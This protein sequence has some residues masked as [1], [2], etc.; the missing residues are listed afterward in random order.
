MSVDIVMRTKDRPFFLSRA[1]DD[2]LAQA[3]TDWRLII[4]NDGGDPELV[5]QTVGHRPELTGRTE[6]IHL[7]ESLGRG[8]AIDRGV[9]AC[10]SEMI[11]WHDDD[12]TWH[13]EFLARTTAFLDSSDADAVAVRTEIVWEQVSSDRVVETGREI[14]HPLMLEPTF[15]DM[16][17]FNH[18]VPIA[19]VY[20]RSVHDRI[21]G[22]DPR[23]MAA[24]DWEFY[25]RLWAQGTVG[26]IDEVLAYWHQRRDA[27][28]DAANSVHGDREAHVRFDRRVRDEAVRDYVQRHGAGE[29]LYLAKYV[30]E[31]TGDLHARID[32]IEENQREALRMIRSLRR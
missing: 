1:L 29:L 14:F 18:V 13:P 10:T 4:V 3:F 16:L 9:A 23:L 22:V 12:D 19:L 20:R 11:V 21:G 24:S 15:F 31:R 17:R 27:R 8:G 7:S 5:D 26:F 28:G 6:V 32:R 30:D 25:L 2:V